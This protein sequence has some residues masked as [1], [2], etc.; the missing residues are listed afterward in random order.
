[1]KRT[2]DEHGIP[3]LGAEDQEETNMVKWRYECV[4]TTCG[5]VELASYAPSATKRCP[6]CGGMLKR[7]EN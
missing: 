5:Y 2:Q 4:V 6:K 1:M 7:V 3:I